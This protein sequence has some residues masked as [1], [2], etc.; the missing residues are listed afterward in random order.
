M[1]GAG[2][3]GGRLARSAGQVNKASGRNQIRQRR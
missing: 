1:A 3:C 2:F